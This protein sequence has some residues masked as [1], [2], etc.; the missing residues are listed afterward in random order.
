MM[1]YFTPKTISKEL[2]RKN[3]HTEVSQNFI[4]FNKSSDALK[5]RSANYGHRP[6]KVRKM[7]IFGRNIFLSYNEIWPAKQKSVLLHSILF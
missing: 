7:N 5:Q 6:N 3:Y 2:S 1:W 4:C